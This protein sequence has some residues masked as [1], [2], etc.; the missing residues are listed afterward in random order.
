MLRASVEKQVRVGIFSPGGRGRQWSGWGESAALAA[1]VFQTAGHG[2][3][4]ISVRRT[5]LPDAVLDFLA[6]N[7]GAVLFL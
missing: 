4:S 5:I 1:P 7:I 6:G 2:V 3:G